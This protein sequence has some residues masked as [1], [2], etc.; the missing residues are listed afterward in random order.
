MRSRDTIMSLIILVDLRT[1]VSLL[2]YG[3]QEE[4]DVEFLL[5]GKRWTAGG[6]LNCV[7]GGGLQGWA[8][9]VLPLVVER[10]RYIK[11]EDDAVLFRGFRVI[12]AWRASRSETD[13]KT[14]DRNT[15]ET[16][17]LTIV[18]TPRGSEEVSA[19]NRLIVIIIIIILI[20][21]GW[22]PVD[23]GADSVVRC[24]KIFLIA[25]INS[26]ISAILSLICCNSS[27]FLHSHRAPLKN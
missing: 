27:S 24:T 20:I 18:R 23:D 14:V 26:V 6:G 10:K 12:A 8:A 4:A 11:H 17:H 13:E 5:L 22:G 7:I 1:S 21:N 25:H 3:T 15:R 9:Q 2:R 16:K 19:S